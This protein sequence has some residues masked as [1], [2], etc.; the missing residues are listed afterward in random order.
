MPDPDPYALPTDPV[1]DDDTPPPNAVRRGLML[2]TLEAGVVGGMV[3]VNEAW[4]VPLL[5]KQLGASAQAIGLLTT[6]PMLVSMAL[7]PIVAPI[8]ARLGGNKRTTLLTCWVQ[9]AG[10][11]LLGLPLHFAG[12]PWALPVGVALAIAINAVGAV[13]GPAWMSWMGELIPRRV[14]GRYSSNRARVHHASRIASALAFAAL[15]SVFVADTAIGLHI[16]LGIATLS[17]LASVWLM[18]RQPEPRPRVP[19]PASATARI[20]AG[21]AR[22]FASF[23]RSLNRTEV[24]RWTLVWATLHAGCAL[25]GPYFMPYWLE[26]TGKGGLGLAQQPYLYSM[27]VYLSTVVRLLAL[28][29][30]GRLVDHFGPAAMLRIA[31]AGIMVVPFGWASSASLTVLI[32][33][34]ILSGLAWC[35]AEC[36]VGVLLFGC[37]SD[38]GHRARLIGYHQSVCCC[39]IAVSTILGGQLLAILPPLD[40][41]PFRTLFAISMV[42]RIPAVILAIRYLP[43]LKDRERLT[44]LWRLI[45]G[46][47]PTITLSRGVMRAFRRF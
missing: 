34:E 44:G 17:R 43:E 20:A 11:L 32:P 8:I 23:L 2:A 35:T 18:N 21:Q 1:G 26:E 10:F 24:G 4:I 33:T 47:Q 14:R 25:S 29:V 31:V 3:A 39:V 36:A 46:L 41:S 19:D 9:I 40:G 28:P 22:D 12:Q 37:S 30:I 38:P 15:M 45:P 13:G 27:L 5:Q 7:G 6:V 42:C 16:L